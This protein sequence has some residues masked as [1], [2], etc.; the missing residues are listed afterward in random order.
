MRQQVAGQSSASPKCQVQP[1]S[2]K[3]PDLHGPPE[4]GTVNFHDSKSCGNRSAYLGPAR[5][6]YRGQRRSRTWQSH[7]ATPQASPL[8]YTAREKDPHQGLRCLRCGPSRA[9]CPG[10]PILL[11]APTLSPA[12]RP[13][14]ASQQSK[15]AACR[16]WAMMSVCWCS[17]CCAGPGTPRPRKGLLR[18][19][20]PGDPACTR[21]LP[22]AIGRRIAEGCLRSPCPPAPPPSLGSPCP[23]PPPPYGDV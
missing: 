16:G 23:P 3:K 1:K 11:G 8:V 5:C 9:P 14:A 4:T 10:S 12:P 22:M 18:V 21:R 17:A 2:H 20:S 19:E 15:E 13:L 6:A 7:R